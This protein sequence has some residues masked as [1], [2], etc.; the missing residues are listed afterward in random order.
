[1][2]T[3]PVDGKRFLATL[4]ARLQT[5]TEANGYP[6]TVKEVAL[7]EGEILMDVPL[8]RCPLIEII[9]GRER[10]EGIKMGG[11]VE[12]VWQIFLRMAAPRTFDD[13]RMQEFQSAVV[14]CVYADG[15]GKPGNEGVSYPEGGT[16]TIVFPRWVGTEKDYNMIESN[17]IWSAQFEFRSSR[18]TYKF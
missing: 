10:H 3:Y 14:R 6:L 9:D 1:M 7:D 8:T 15:Y 16:N 11:Q 17:R 12:H 5:I 18:W 2:P 4:K 13:L